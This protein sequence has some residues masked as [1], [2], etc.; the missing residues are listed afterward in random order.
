MSVFYFVR[1]GANPFLASD[2]IA[3]RTHGVHLNAEG[4]AQ[5]AAAA[6]MLRR[7]PI[8]KIFSS[9][10]ER[11]RETAEPF[12]KLSGLTVET[13]DGLLEVSFGDWTGMTHGQLS[14]DPRWALWNSFRLGGRIPNGESML[15]VQARMCACV[16]SLRAKFPDGHMAVFGHAD[17]IRAALMYYLGMSLDFYGRLQISPGSI[18]ILNVWE[19]WVELT[20]LNITPPLLP[21]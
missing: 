12:A 2:R 9:P 20:A 7:Y 21:A 18:S 13:L 15:E 11:A 17:P 10:L 14:R 1:H 19:N 8:T 3:G 16:E 6:A 5:A 4:I